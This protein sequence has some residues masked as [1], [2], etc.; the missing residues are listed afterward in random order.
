[1]NNDSQHDLRQHVKTVL[2]RSADELDAETRAELAKRR[3]AVLADTGERS[4]RWRWLIPTSAITATAVMAWLAVS[5][6]GIKPNVETLPPSS[7]ELELLTSM[8]DIEFYGEIDMIE[9]MDHE[10]IEG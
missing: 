8:E 6:V 5:Y 3:R 2:D 1:M 4:A 10:N 9:W 7:E